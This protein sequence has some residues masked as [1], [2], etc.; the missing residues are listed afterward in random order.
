MSATLSARA[1]CLSARASS[2][3]DHVFVFPE[4]APEFDQ[5]GV[6][7]I[8]VGRDLEQL[9]VEILGPG[10][11]F[12]PC[13]THARAPLQKALPDFQRLRPI[14]NEVFGR[15]QD[16]RDALGE[17][18]CSGGGLQR[19]RRGVVL[20]MAGNGGDERLEVLRRQRAQ[21]RLSNAAEVDERRQSGRGVRRALVGSFDSSRC[22]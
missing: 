17:L 22:T 2:T 19:E 10:P 5:P 8:V 1:V 7:E 20:R 4:P 13:A 9:G 3:L 14:R 12:R 18:R 16:A 6:R 11:G 15:E 21:R